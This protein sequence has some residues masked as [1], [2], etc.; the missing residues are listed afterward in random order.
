[1]AIADSS[2]ETMRRSI[3]FILAA[4]AATAPVAA[5]QPI[6]P[7]LKTYVPVAITLPAAST[8]ASFAA[9][10]AELAIVAKSR[11]YA[12]L[13]RLVQ[14]QG[15]FW[16]RDFARAF[17]PRKPAVDNLAA[18]IQLEH[19]NG[20]GWTLL[21]AL[22]TEA[23]VEPMASRPGVVCAP[24]NPSYDGV[25]F[26]RLLDATHTGVSDWVYPRAAETKVQAAPQ[27]AA[28][29]LGTLGPQFVRLLGFEGAGG[30]PA[31]ERKLWARVA[32]PDA[33]SGFVAPGNL[34]SLTAERLCYIYDLVG[35]WR[36]AGYVAAGE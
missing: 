9:F 21:A 8:D 4:L 3:P 32:T 26:A 14:S 10:R 2:T 17:D 24:A 33:N 27:P 28:A 25:A 18:A 22:A 1:V 20:S 13:G 35:G 12:A 15:F 29:V 34:M 19:R 31:P 36:I 11:V 7:P 23:A 16:D 6:L 30:Q 5:A